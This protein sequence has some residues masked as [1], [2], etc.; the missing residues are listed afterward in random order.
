MQM[1]RDD[2]CSVL[3][4]SEWKVYLQLILLET[5]TGSIASRATRS[6]AAAQSVGSVE[7]V[8][9]LIP[10]SSP[11]VCPGGFRDVAAYPAA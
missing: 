9:A 6:S 11:A 7:S 5:H 10:Q 2:C 8:T 3:S 4:S 1:G